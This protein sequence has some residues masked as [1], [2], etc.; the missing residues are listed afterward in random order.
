MIIAR[1]PLGTIRT[2]TLF[3]TVFAALSGS[4]QERRTMD[5]GFDPR[6]GFT[7]QDSTSST[8]FKTTSP[9]GQLQAETGFRE[10]RVTSAEDSRP[11]QEF[12]TSGHTVSPLFSHDGTA[13]I[14][15][16]CRG[17]LGCISTVY[18]WDL[19]TGTRTRVG[20]CSGTVTDIS[21]DEE[22]RRI[23]VTTDYGHLFSFLHANRTGKYYGG[24]LVIFDSRQTKRIC[25][26][27]L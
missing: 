2:V 20:E 17:N 7:F 10:I 14:A 13:L 26:G 4:A 6:M 23:A 3:V 24:E 15:A 27:F 16:V 25:S 5:E 21:A 19:K 8:L 11:L 1:T 9:N 18:S 12:A 22:S